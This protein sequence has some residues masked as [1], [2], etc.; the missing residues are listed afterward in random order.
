[1]CEQNL[2]KPDTRIRGTGVVWRMEARGTDGGG[3]GGGAFI[4]SY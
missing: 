1:M 4:L 3:G 2:T